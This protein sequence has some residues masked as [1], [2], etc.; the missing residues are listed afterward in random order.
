[1]EHLCLNEMGQPEEFM[2]FLQQ[3]Y[4]WI[5]D[6]VKSEVK[7]ENLD[8]DLDDYEVEEAASLIHRHFGRSRRFAE[9]DK[10]TMTTLVATRSQVLYISFINKP[11]KPEFLKTL[12]T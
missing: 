9:R 3:E 4:G 5:Y 7:A 6:E 2:D 10:K 12:S 8:L 1:M 11:N